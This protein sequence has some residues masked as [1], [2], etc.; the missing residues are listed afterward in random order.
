MLPFLLQIYTHFH[1]IYADVANSMFKYEKFNHKSD[2]WMKYKKFEL[3]E[4]NKCN[5]VHMEG[6]NKI[7]LSYDC[8][9]FIQ[10]YLSLA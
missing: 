6:T 5:G 2:G 4:K 10:F 9:I 8:S 1:L 7:L 3:Q